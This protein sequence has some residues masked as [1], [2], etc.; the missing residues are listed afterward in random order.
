MSDAD[1]RSKLD[2]KKCRYKIKKD[3]P[4]LVLHE[5]SFID[6]SPLSVL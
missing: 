4:L 1:F 6:Y 3:L 2:F 5:K